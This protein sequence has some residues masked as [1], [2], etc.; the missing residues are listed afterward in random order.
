MPFIRDPEALERQGALSLLESIDTRFDVHA[1]LARLRQ[2]ADPAVVGADLG[3]DL[4][5]LL[6]ALQQARQQITSLQR[7]YTDC[8]QANR[9]EALRAALRHAQAHI[10]ALSE[11]EPALEQA[12]REKASAEQRAAY[13]QREV[14]RLEAALAEQQLLIAR[15]QERLAAL[16]G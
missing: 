16:S 8:S 15:Q 9:E 4:R 14:E 5:G 2:G 1:A 3:R 7:L 12:R 10:T 11:L 13:L 6:Y